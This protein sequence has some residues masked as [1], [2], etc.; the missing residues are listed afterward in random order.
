M[1][2][3]SLKHVQNQGSLMGAPWYVGTDIPVET[4]KNAWPSGNA[5]T[6]QAGGV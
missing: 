3:M 4:R 2:I 5:H 1:L 6:R